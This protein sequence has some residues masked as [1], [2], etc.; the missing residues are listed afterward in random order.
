MPPTLPTASPSPKRKRDG[1]L[2]GPTFSPSKLT[3]PNFCPPINGHKRSG[4]TN[5][6]RKFNVEVRGGREGM[7]Q[8]SDGASSEEDTREKITGGVRDLQLEEPGKEE[9]TIVRDGMD[10]EDERAAEEIKRRRKRTARKAATDVGALIEQPGPRTT[11]TGVP[12]WDNYISPPS[13]SKSRQ[14]PKANTYPPPARDQGTLSP[15]PTDPQGLTPYNSAPPPAPMTSPLPSPSAS[16]PPKKNSRPP[17]R[18]PH[19][20]AH[21]PAVPGIPFPAIHKP[22]SGRR[23]RSPP[24]PKRTSP[25]PRRSSY[26]PPP[27]SAGPEGSNPNGSNDSSL[28]EPPDSDSEDSS[29]GLNGIGYRPTPAIAWQR[30]EKRRE[31]VREYKAREAGEERK[32]RAERRRRGDGQ[33][34][35]HSQDGE[36]D[37]SGDGARRVRFAED[38]SA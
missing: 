5:G 3:P 21:L 18:V 34:G 22:V 31:Q 20:L 6:T 4:S 24:P 1:S 23:S 8:V 25:P 36:G 19:G 15:H 27:D 10:E 33:N 17:Q 38:K 12:P 35:R 9:R 16:P 11:S 2:S 28:G 32:R 14:P 7:R 29:T 30:K 13:P 37:G 26:S